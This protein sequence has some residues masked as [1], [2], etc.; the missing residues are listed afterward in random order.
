MK[1]YFSFFFFA[2]LAMFLVGCD[3][4]APYYP[5]GDDSDGSKTYL[6][7]SSYSDLTHNSVVV[8]A[9]T[10][11]DE[12][13][14]E[15]VEYGFVYSTNKDDIE[16][17]D[18]IVWADNGERDEDVYSY[19]A[20]IS[21]LTADEQYYY[22]AM[23]RLNEAECKYGKIEEFT[24]TAMPDDPNPNDLPMLESP[25]YG[26]VTIALRASAATCNGMIAVGAATNWDGT[27]DW[28]PSAQN[29]RFTKVEDTE[30]WYQITLPAN[31]DMSVKVIAVTLEGIADWG[32]QWGRNV[33]GEE[34]SVVL[35][36]G[37]GYLDN[38]EN[39]GEVRLM[40]LVENTVVY[41]DVLAWQSDPCIE[42][43][44]EGWATFRV[45]VPD[46]TPINAQVS[47]AGSFYENTWTPGAYLLERQSDG[48]YYGEF[49]IPAAFQYKYIVGFAGME[50]SW[51]YVEVSENRVMPLDM[52]AYDVVE[53]WFNIPAP[54]PSNHEWV[55]LGLPSGL[56]WAT[57]N[58]GASQPEEYGDYFAWGEV[59]PKDYYDWSTYKWCNGTENTQT[60]YCNDSYYGYN[61]FTDYKT[62]LDLSDDA[63]NYN[64]GGGWRMPTEEEQD[65]LRNNCSWEWT[66]K[67][68][69][70]GRKVTGPNGN[71]IF[72]PAAGFC[73]DSS[74]SYAGSLGY[75]RS[76]SLGTYDPSYASELCFSYHNVGWDGSDRYY[77]FSVRPVCQ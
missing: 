39:N 42:K 59:E 8:Y 9:E 44:A 50:W 74:L 71:S 23:V 41:V 37:D 73:Y 13:N 55:D 46:N 48:T 36:K 30:N 67:N 68:G 21:N 56:K 54:N 17:S 38:F 15:S 60:K 66:S 76:S 34:P 28:D 19:S 24:T 20:T 10:N 11:L 63:A 64:W 43:N 4:P 57:C 75:Y 61:G 58:V 5:S 16:Y 29:K 49:Y 62:T 45:I 72:L 12:S 2:L 52:H 22:C 65:E 31:P 51:E 40:E 47:I 7:T 26:K 33:N 77:G 53:M 1:K 32:T 3:S 70:Y 18:N 25:G 14:Y 27:D 69:V 35:L 6:K